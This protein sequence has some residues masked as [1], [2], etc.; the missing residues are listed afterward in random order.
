MQLTL[1]FEEGSHSSV[2]LLSLGKIVVVSLLSGE[3]IVI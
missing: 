1:K 2:C 3:K